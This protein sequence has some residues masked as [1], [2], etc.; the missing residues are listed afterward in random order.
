MLR[1]QVV[2][3]DNYYM[4]TPCINDTIINSYFVTIITKQ[5]IIGQKK[6]QVS[7]Q[8]TTN[9]SKNTHPQV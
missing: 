6:K 9:K 7:C 3:A 2:E 4:F 1:R 8:K 5:P